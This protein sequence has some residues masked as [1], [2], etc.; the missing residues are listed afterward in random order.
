MTAPPERPA[1]PAGSLVRGLGVRSAVA[2]VVGAVIGSGVFLVAADIRASVPSPAWGVAVWIAAGLAS[3]IGGLTFAE[4]GGRFPGAGGQYV[5]LREA[6][7]P[8]IAFLFGWTLFLVI[9]AGSIAAVA[10]AFAGVLG[11]LVPLSAAGQTAI[12]TAVIGASTS[13]H[14]LGVQR[15]GRVLEVLSA[16]KV[17]ALVGIGVAGLVLSP[18]SIRDLTVTPHPTVASFGVA[19]IAAFWAYDGWN[20]V[21][22]LAG[23]VRDPRRSV[24]LAMVGGIAIVGVLYV[25]VNLAIHLALSPD[26]LARAAHPAIDA[27][28]RLAGSRAGT[29]ILLC[30][31]LSTIGCVHGLVMAGARVPYAMAQDGAVP[32]MLARLTPHTHAPSVALL[33]QMAWSI[34]LVVSGTYDE[35][36]TYVIAAAFVFYGLCGVAVIVLRRRAPNTER[37]FSVP[38]YPWVPLAYALF[39]TAFVINA[40]REK[41][42]ASLAGLGIVAGGVPAYAWFTRRRRS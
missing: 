41:P 28:T 23:E 18:R 5:Y 12:A 24:P 40:C 21:G 8:R 38:L 7:G 33:L 10:A 1:P 36:F 26:E 16:L 13:V 6:F 32:A 11:D 17:L 34:V 29:A 9:Q 22:Y 19:L 42:L 2:V 37:A 14:L 39:C 30:I 20:N 27:A 15:G 4:L 3:L 31:L 35:L 25:L